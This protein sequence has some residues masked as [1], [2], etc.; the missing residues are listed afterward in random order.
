MLPD[1]WESRSVGDLCN[2]VNG[3]GFKSSEW[4]TEGFPIIRIQ[5]LN[6]STEFNYFN[7]EVQNRWLVEHGDILFAW[8]GTKGVSFGAKRWLGSRGVLNQHIFRVEPKQAVDSAWLYSALTRVTERI[9]QKAHGFK[10]TLL[11]VQK[12]DITEQVVAVPPL[13]EQQKIARIL[14]TWDEAISA[15]E[16]LLA[17]SEL[18]KNALM[19]QL[20]TGKKRLSKFKDGWKVK[21][22]SD[23]LAESR[24]QGSS[25]ENAKKLTV[26][27]YGRGVTAKR[28]VRKG[29][30]STKYYRRSAGQFIYSKLDFLNGAFG[31]IP[32]RLDG[33]ES[34]LDLPAFDFL[35][36]IDPLWFYY[37]VSR[38]DFY[39]SNIG[40]ANG[41]RKARR[42]NPK[43]FLNIQI[44]VPAVEEQQKIAQV[45]KIADH[46]V[47]LLKRHRSTLQS[48]KRALMQQLLTGKRRVKV[49]EAQTDAVTT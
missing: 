35:D 48:E 17:N 29:S 10:T 44:C 33:Y 19:Q 23:F 18:Q 41:G 14:S 1:G 4:S 6:G 24:I 36:G 8:A 3:N 11:H 20:M 39:I 27:L 5:N 43:D 40:L 38:E 42:V 13:F 21:R 49:D 2:F 30:A 25:G 16:Q 22:I 26:K 46:E 34:T 47:S 45:L 7:G 31:I 32:N 15:T 28:E 37:H 12:S 9:E